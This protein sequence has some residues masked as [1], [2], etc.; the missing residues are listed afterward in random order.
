MCVLIDKIGIYSEDINTMKKHSE[1][2]LGVV[3]NCCSSLKVE[4]ELSISLHP[5]FSGKYG[6]ELMSEFCEARGF[7][8]MDSLMFT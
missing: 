4:Q 8:L 7:C 3:K 6:E 5:S 2:S 1:A